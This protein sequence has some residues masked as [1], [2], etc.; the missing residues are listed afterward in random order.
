MQ[1]P[2]RRVQRLCDAAVSVAFMVAIWSSLLCWGLGWD[3]PNTYT[4]KRAL[5][6][7]PSL[8]LSEKAVRAFPSRFDAYFKDRFGLRNT[9]IRLHNRALF[10]LGVSPSPRVTLGREGWLYY[11]GPH[12]QREDPIS[13]FRGTRPLSAARL[14]RWRW[15]LED[16]HDWLAQKG[17]RYLL[18]FVPGKPH[19][20]SEYMPERFNKVGPLTPLEQT[21]RYLAE[22]AKAP[23]LSLSSA[24]W[25]ARGIEPV[26]PRTDSHWNDFGAYMGCRAIIERIGEWFPN[27]K[28]IPPSAYRRA[29]ADVNGDLARMLNLEALLRERYLAMRFRDPELRATL[30]EDR[31]LKTHLVGGTGDERLPRALVYRDSFGEELAP[32]LAPYF[33]HVVFKWQAVGMVLRQ[34]ERAEPDLVLQIVGAR[35]L[36]AGQ[37]YPTTIRWEM[38]RERFEAAEHVLFRFDPETGFADAVPV[39]DTRVR[40]VPDGLVAEAPSPGA[41]QLSLPAIEQVRALCPIIE[42]DITAPEQTRIRVW[43]ERAS[44][45]DPGEHLRPYISGRVEGGRQK[46]YFPLKDPEIVGPLRLDIAP[47]GRA[48]HIHRIEARGVPR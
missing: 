18:V 3:A 39:A 26:Y 16:Q 41:V 13:D 15:F 42:L 17:I 9:L 34:I 21:E 20:Y 5:N 23:F 45:A 6:P 19:I 25:E 47:S 36:R 14:E 35:G 12:P 1:A 33:S 7:F 40:N 8:E 31:E 37:R 22:H 30:P 38:A 24:L 48:Y 28:V 29:R 2:V 4:E 43:W 11:Q 46:V 44:K 10:E 32:H 27:L